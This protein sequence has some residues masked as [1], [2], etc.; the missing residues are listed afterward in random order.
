MKFDFAKIWA[1]IDQLFR[2][3][4]EKFKGFEIGGDAE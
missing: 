4:W 1:V 3:L 2:A